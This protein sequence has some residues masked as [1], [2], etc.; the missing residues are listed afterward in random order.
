MDALNVAGLTFA[1]PGCD[2][3][4]LDA[5]SFDVPAGAFVVVCGRSGGG[6]STLLR[7]LKP[8]L[9]PHGTRSGVVRYF[10]QPIDAMGPREQA[11]QI[12][13]VLQNPDNQLVTETVAHE[14]AFGLENL[15]LPSEVVRMR[16][17]EMASFFGMADG[18]ERSVQELSGGQ[19]Q[20]VNLAAVMALQ[21]RLLVLDEPTAQLDPIA[22]TEFLGTLRRINQELGIT[23]VL[24]EQRLEEVL[25]LADRVLVLDAGRVLAYDTPRSVCHT[26]AV[27]QRD[28]FQ[29]MPTAAR[30]AAA[31]AD[32]A[33]AVADEAARDAECMPEAAAC[34]LCS[35]TS[36]AAA[37]ESRV[38]TDDA[39]ACEPCASADDDA[40][41]GEGVGCSSFDHER[42][43][44]SELPL[45]VREGRAWLARH[46]REQVGDAPNEAHVPDAAA[47]AVNNHSS[48]QAGNITCS[49]DVPT[50]NVRCTA[51]TLQ[52]QAVLSESAPTPDAPVIELRGVWFRYEKTAPDVLRG[53]SLT[54]AR[55]SWH[56]LLGAN[57][58]GKSTLL[59]MASGLDRPYRGSVRF[60]GR[61]L[62]PRLA[63]TL[64]GGVM[65]VLPQNPQTLFVAPTVEENLLDMLP[66]QVAAGERAATLGRVCELLELGRLRGMHPFDLSGGEQ[67]RV[68]LGQ[69]LMRKPRVLLLDEPTKGL[70]APFKEQLAQVLHHLQDAGVTIMMVS[71]DIEFCARHATTCSLLFQ[72]DIVRTAPT[73]AFFAG[74]SFY[75]TAANRMARGIVPNAV[76]DEEV[77][78]AC[79]IL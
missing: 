69:L 46:V 25:P 79:R 22:A 38:G 8:Q 71:H 17:A 15:G 16:V 70:D 44:V 43:G 57:G 78:A 26:L 65:G 36:D 37:H 41:H 7:H 27:T 74:N 13:F 1:Y 5:V 2:Q 19:K 72:G 24:S 14:L 4:A 59:G 64:H 56:C 47:S 21:P 53:L 48:I 45:T 49:S 60:E 73:H 62:T 67:Q 33:A 6:K 58:A 52:Q 55:G 42:T 63:R 34:E 31:V 18:F 77:I 39:T 3:P 75:T 68:A 35:G 40:A 54:V 23:V 61:S 12:G 50:S 11:A 51:D 20:L 32:E 10:G 30:V 76:T 66:P 9:A 29:A 28:L